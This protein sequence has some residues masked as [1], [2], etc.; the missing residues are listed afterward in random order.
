MS[1]SVRIASANDN[2]NA[3]GLFSWDL[4]TNT[5]YADAALATAFGMNPTE[6][7]RGL[8]V[9]AYL[10]HVYL[11]DRPVLAKAI[12]DAIQSGKP[13]QI[14]YRAVGADGQLT[15]VTAFAK[16]FHDDMGEP[17][18]YAGIVFPL[19]D[20]VPGDVDLRWLCIAAIDKAIQD[21]RNDVVPLLQQALMRVAGNRQ[22]HAQP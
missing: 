22:P 6:A 10:Q 8:P 18:A 3:A 21:G 2:D 1:Q 16:C 9:E 17:K 15:P 7:E 20:S 4:Q 5:L 14:S 12:A 13:V 11:D 19:P